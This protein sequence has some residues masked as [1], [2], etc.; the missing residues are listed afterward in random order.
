MTERL[1]LSVPADGVADL[2]AL[3]RRAEQRGWSDLW[4]ME[5][6]DLDAFT[7]LAAA[8]G[9]TERLR[10]GSAIVAAFLRPPGVTAMQAAGVAALAP[11]RF[12]LGLGA[13]TKV[14]VEQWHGVPFPDRPVAALAERAEQIVRLLRGEKVGGLRLGIPPSEPVPLYLA[15]LG[16]RALAL[17]GEIADGVVLFLVGPGRLPEVLRQVGD[18]KDSVARIFAFPANGTDV[19][20]RAR[21][22]IV[23][24]T[25]VPYY[26]R[27]LTSQGFGEEVAAI[28]EAWRSGERERAVGLVSDAMVRELTLT[29]SDDDIADG[30]QA[31]RRAGLGTPLVATSTGAEARRLVEALGPER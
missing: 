16:P 8:A 3:A 21:R 18:G 23:P 25:L 28:G 26:A 27:S 24:Y 6:R 4:S 9:V 19:H 10:L 11:G 1:G 2:T 12:A 14:V 7:P 29:G 31:Y 15:A 5:S 30:I 13:S 17:T 22:L 20:A